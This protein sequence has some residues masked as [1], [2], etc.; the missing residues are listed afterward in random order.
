MDEPQVNVCSRCAWSSMSL[1]PKSAEGSISIK[2]RA[3]GI[4]STTP[5]SSSDKQLN[6]EF[7]SAA[8]S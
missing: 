7:C 1:T 3:Q 8:L 5:V 6:L 4:D 2:R